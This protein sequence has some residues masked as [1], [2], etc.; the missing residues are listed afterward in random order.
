MKKELIHSAEGFYNALAK[1]YHLVYQNWDASIQRQA[2]VIDQLIQKYLAQKPNKIL[3][4]TCGIGTQTLGLSGL[5]YTLHGTDIS[6]ASIER[7]QREAEKRQLSATFQVADVRYLQL[8]VAGRF[9]VV[10]SFDNSLPHL[11]DK[12]D[13]LLA[14]EGIKAKLSETGVFL[15]STRDYDLLLKEKPRST[16]PITST[17]E[18]VKTITFQL[19]DWRED[20]TYIV[21]HFT[22][23][24]LNDEFETNVRKAEYAAFTRAEMSHIFKEAGFTTIQWLM[25]EESGFYQPIFVALP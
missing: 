12:G 4:C 14:A 17:T 24:G 20:N 9:D 11:K 2:K 6:S 8:D 5:G 23:K 19:W 13:L 1:D 15:G 21:D 7:A 16:Q 22:L 3:D 25:P 18:D 10:I